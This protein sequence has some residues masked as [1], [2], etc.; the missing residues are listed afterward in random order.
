MVPVL[1]A[2]VWC[3]HPPQPD[4]GFPLKF[5]EINIGA[6]EQAHAAVMAVAVGKAAPRKAD[7]AALFVLE[8][9]V[10][11]HLDFLDSGFLFSAGAPQVPSQHVFLRVHR[12]AG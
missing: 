5:L 8:I 1:P 6:G 4:G 9:Q 11:T 7:R 10:I 3:P 2:E 12:T